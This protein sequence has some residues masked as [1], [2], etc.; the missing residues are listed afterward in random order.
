MCVEP[1]CLTDY[2]SFYTNR[3][4]RTAPVCKARKL[5]KF[6]GVNHIVDKGQCF[7]FYVLVK[8]SNHFKVPML[9]IIFYVVK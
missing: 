1:L 6:I 8:E 9:I 5:V 2:M 3:N 4:T 7:F